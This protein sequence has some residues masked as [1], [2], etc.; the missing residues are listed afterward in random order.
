VSEALSKRE[1]EVLAELS[2][3]GRVSGIAERLFISPHTVRNHLRSI[4]GKLGVHSQAELVEYVKQNPAVLGEMRR[5]GLRTDDDPAALLQRYA[6]AN[7][8]LAAQ[9]DAVFDERWG[10]DGLREIIR[11][12]LPLDETGKQA[13]QARLDLWSRERGEPALA[14]MRSNEIAPWRGRMRERIEHAQ[15]EGWIRDDQS[16]EEILEGFSSMMVGSALQLLK[17][18]SPVAETVQLRLVEAFIQDIVIE[19]E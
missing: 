17:D 4:F 18:Y 3:G 1:S 9:I 7:E 2:A 5:S 6:E 15:T 16:A 8:R 14:D 12:V 10:P 11:V 13:W 19:G